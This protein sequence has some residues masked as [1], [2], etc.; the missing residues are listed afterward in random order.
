MKDQ[1]ALGLRSLAIEKDLDQLRDRLE[2]IGGV[3]DEYKD[4]VEADTS[5]RRLRE[6]ARSVAKNTKEMLQDARP[7]RLGII[8]QVKAGKSSL[9]NLLLFD[10]HKVLPEAATP[11]T[12]SLTHIL[13]SERD[14][15]GIEYYTRE[16]WRDINGLAREYGRA[17]RDGDESIPRSVEAAAQLVEMAD[18]NHLNTHDYL[19][20]RETSEVPMAMLNKHLGRFVG[21]DGHFTPLVKSVTIRTSQGIPDLDIVDT[22]GINDPIVSRSQQ[23]EDMLARCDAVLMLSYA[24]QFMDA[25][26]VAFFER[27]APQEGI[28]HRIIVGSKFDSA[29]IDVSRDYRGLLDEA[30]AETEQL[31]AK[32]AAELTA[33]DNDAPMMPSDPNPNV[34]LM[35]ALCAAL[36]QKSVASWAAAES[37]A[38]DLLQCAYPDWF[39]KPDAGRTLNQTTK[40]H[41]AWIGNRAAVEERLREARAN[42]NRIIAEKM[43]DFRRVKHTAALETLDELIGNLE[44]RR[45]AVEAG[46]IRDIESRIKAV[47]EAEEKLD[48]KVRSVW[49]ELVK[50]Q[51]TPWKVLRDDVRKHQMQELGAIGDLVK[52]EPATGTRVK[53]GFWP[54][55]A[56]FFWGGGEES[57]SYEKK[58]LDKGRLNNRMRLFAGHTQ[59]KVRDVVDAMFDDE[60]ADKAAGMLRSVIGDSLGDHVAGNIDDV[61]LRLASVEAARNIVDES[62][63]RVLA[64]RGKLDESLDLTFRPPE[65]KSATRMREAGEDFVNEKT[66]QIIKW[67]EDQRKKMDDVYD[68]AK[69]RLVPAAVEELKRYQER[70]REDIENRKFTL[71]RYGLVLGE[72]GHVRQRLVDAP[73]ST[74]A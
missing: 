29:L 13:K 33:A 36:S 44:Q 26:D 3:I 56:N 64:D 15:V 58:V 4:I 34:V 47:S 16:D 50:E 63:K 38:F 39:D 42:K 62:R 17:K 12:A 41:L 45:T 68:L 7:L 55:F 51:R 30:K 49:V 25:Q 19:G 35:S 54:G 43:Q 61:L 65:G 18:S 66:D 52:L 10:G 73:A 27:M 67:I 22:P 46:D 6:M 60:F 31:L 37:H 23:A 2:A 59:D 24:G 53:S 32:R 5:V 57:Y 72:L 28:R 74:D 69:T 20:K 70:L 11:M 14:E 9:L 8:G 48:A 1:M 21:A 40:E 71:L